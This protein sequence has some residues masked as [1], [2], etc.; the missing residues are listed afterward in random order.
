MLLLCP[1]A[2]G[3]LCCGV[4]VVVFAFALPKLYEARKDDVDKVL[5]KVGVGEDLGGAVGEREGSREGACVQC[6]WSC[7]GRA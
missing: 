3:A 1:C 7:L 6:H 4:A 5:V 2:C